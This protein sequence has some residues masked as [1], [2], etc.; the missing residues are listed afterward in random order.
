MNISQLVSCWSTKICNVLIM[1]GNEAGIHSTH[2]AS[3]A[4]AGGKYS[5]NRDRRNSR[6]KGYR[7][8]FITVATQSGSCLVQCLCG[9]NFMLRR[10]LLAQANAIALLVRSREWRILV[11]KWDNSVVPRRG[12]TLDEHILSSIFTAR[13]K[14]KQTYILKG[15]DDGV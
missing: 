7:C 14:R 10:F 8:Y 13:Y 9:A 15:S 2:T 11:W 4:M 5:R 3:T 6:S 1:A 12:L